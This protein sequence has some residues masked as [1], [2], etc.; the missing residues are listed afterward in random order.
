MWDGESFV[1][2]FDQARKY[3]QPSDVSCEMQD[4]L[5]HPPFATI[6]P[7]SK[8]FL[9]VVPVRRQMEKGRWAGGPK[10]DGSK[11]EVTAQQP[12][13]GRLHFLT[14]QSFDHSPC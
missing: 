8:H 1:D 7:L 14:T 10:I 9:R 3:W 11:N 6:R 13:L 12:F 5:A 2:D 4:I